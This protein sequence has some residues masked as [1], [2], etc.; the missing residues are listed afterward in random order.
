[1]AGP[2]FSGMDA[3]LTTPGR[4]LPPEV[5][6]GVAAVPLGRLRPWPG[7]P[8]RIAPARLDDLKRALLDDPMML[9]WRP[10]I[11]RLDGTVVCGNHRLLAAIVLGWNSI[12]VLYVD[13][14]DERAR[15]WALRDNNAWA[16]WDEPVLAELLAELAA[17]G[18]ELA[19]TGFESRDL[20]RI[21]AGF[22][23]P[24]DPDDAP[25]LPAGAPESQP[26][27]V[28]PLGD[29]LLLCGDSRQAD[30][31]ARLLGQERAEVLL[32]DPPYGV[33]YIGKTERRLRIRNDD[34]D[35]LPALLDDAFAAADAVLA[36]SARFYIASPT[37]PR[38]TIFRLALDHVGWRFHQELVW[39]KNSPVLGHSDYHLQHEAVLYGWKPGPGRPGRGRHAGSRWSGDNRQT[40]VMFFDRPSR[41]TAHPTMKPVALLETLLRNSTRRGDIVFE[42]FAG[43]GSTLIACERLGRRCFA[44]EIDPAY[45][46]VIRRRYQEHTHG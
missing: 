34:P 44:V 12:P 3:A 37:G 4:R 20:D 18:V 13:I 19:L 25:A 23:Q 9:W 15:M 36:P 46:D 14:D 32:T 35:G 17:G 22:E 1:M 6:A 39:A 10:L 24:A 42:P 21:L 31:V 28:Y 26:G 33:D 8:R 30:P 43:S 29:H 45:C 38:G 7:N 11:A 16:E 27:E 5:A 41:S 2:R 40:S